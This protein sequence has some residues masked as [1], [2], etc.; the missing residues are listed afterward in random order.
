MNAKH[1]PKTQ[2]WLASALVVLL[3]AA[4]G[5]KTSSPADIFVQANAGRNNVT[6]QV[7]GGG[8]SQPLL[9]AQSAQLFTGDSV[10]VDTSGQAILRFSDFLTV[11]VLRD[12]DLVVR[13]LD[14]ADQSALAV[15]GQ[16]GGAFVNDMAPGSGD[17]KRRVTVE[18][19]FATIT[20]T[21]TR[22]MIAKEA[23]SPLEWV[24]GLDA[25]V[26]DLYVQAKNDADP[27]NR[28]PVESGM[29]RWIAPLGE[30]S[31]GIAYDVQKVNAWL[32]TMKSGGEVPEVGTVLWP[33][34]DMRIDLESVPKEDVRGKTVDIGGIAT[35][36]AASTE[37]GTPSYTWTDCN[38]DGI[39]DMLMENGVIDWDFRTLTNRVSALD[40]TLV[41]FDGTA[42]GTVQT[43][44]PAQNVI[45]RKAF[46]LREGQGDVISMRAD[47]PYH[48]ARLT[49]AKGCFLGISLTPPQADGT[50]AA[51]QPAVDVWPPALTP[52]TRP[53][54]ISANTCEIVYAGSD[55]L[56]L[57]AGPGV[58]Y[59]PPITPLYAGVILEPLARSADGGWIQV[60]VTGKDLK[61]W[62]SSGRAYVRCEQNI[63]DLPV[64]R[65]PATPTPTP[66]PQAYVRIDQPRDN[67]T[68]ATGFLLAGESSWPFEG[69]LNILIESLDGQPIQT[70]FVMVDSRGGEPYSSDPAF[71]QKQIFVDTSLPAN[72]RVRVQQISARDGSVEAEDSVVLRPLNINN[73]G[74]RRS[75]ANGVMSAWPVNG[76]GTSALQ[77]GMDMDGSPIEWQS[78]QSEFGVS[79]V[80]ISAA[81]Y[82]NGCAVQTPSLSTRASIDL[83]GQALLAYDYAALYVAFF[84][85]D[86][87]YVPYAGKDERF[88]LGDSPQLLLDLD[89]GGDFTDG[90]NSVDDVQIEFHPGT[91]GEG[92]DGFDA[93]AALWHLNPESS[94][95][96]DAAVASSQSALG[97]FVEAAIPW[98]SLGL[99]APPPWGMGAAVN[100]S[101]NDTPTTARQECMISSS[102]N[103][104]LKSPTTW[105]TLDLVVFQ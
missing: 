72:V 102:P 57:R 76:D 81:V 89:L 45:A 31:A 34:A 82:D 5:D 56:N 66:T 3:L 22:F 35:S 18:T 69:T 94:Q 93:R 2:S 103:Y 33:T 71:F 64:G 8:S 12:G 43:F 86:D 14:L 29:A 23:N 16:S 61:G 88:F 62:V 79:P 1:E 63:A 59:D 67:A 17:V 47:Q 105:G 25:G 68:T 51:P 52:P 55:G 73:T 80:A 84:V 46:K 83:A 54:P 60:I 4:C 99:T 38:A 101:D 90:A 78:L 21:G 40:V 44:D 85:R 58:A 65:A 6:V 42:E 26:D 28:K 50:D 32:K 7:G 104:A 11:E 92:G 24:F 70:D 30:P 75:D 27:A 20:A 95:P 74:V 53:T 13:E 49:L 96:L 100:I 48:Y 91:F 10:D 37:F 39:E 98:S 87:L 77:I 9:P 97:Y 19:E 36:M 15:F 41:A